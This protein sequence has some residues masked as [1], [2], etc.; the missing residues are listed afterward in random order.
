MQSLKSG[1]TIAILC[2]FF[3]FDS[4]AQENPVTASGGTNFGLSVRSSFSFTGVNLALT[5]DM[6]NDRLILFA[7]P[8]VSLTRSYRPWKGPFGIH[9]GGNFILNPKSKWQSLLHFQYQIVFDGKSSGPVDYIHEFL[10]GY[11]FRYRVSDQVFIGNSLGFGIFRQSN[12][13]VTLNDRKGRTG[14][15]GLVQVN[16]GYEF[17]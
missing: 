10:G 15:N 6:R 13:V 4:R 8:K 11:G 17:N 12:Y 14:T 3:A 7:G 2:L 9:A 5:L 1:F 16:L